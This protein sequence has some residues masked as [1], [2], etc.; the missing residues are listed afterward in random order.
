MN[1]VVGSSISHTLKLFT[2]ATPKMSQFRSLDAA[3]GRCH[4]SLRFCPKCASTANLSWEQ[5]AVYPW[6]TVLCCSSCDIRWY[7]CRE[8][9]GVRSHYTKVPQL[10]RHARNCH[11]ISGAA[12]SNT[13]N[14]TPSTSRAESPAF[15]DTTGD[16]LFE[17][18]VSDPTHSAYPVCEVES[19]SSNQFHCVAS[20]SIIDV[21]EMKGLNSLSEKYFKHQFIDKQGGLAHVVAMSQFQVE[22]YR[23]SQNIATPEIQYHLDF[24]MLVSKLSRA[25]RS[26]LADVIKQTVSITT[27]RITSPASSSSDG[28]YKA[29]AIATTAEQIRSTYV[30]GKYAMLQNLPR[31]QVTSFDGHGYVSLRECISDILAHGLDLDDIVSQSENPLVAKLSECKVSQSIFDNASLR[32]VGTEQPIVLYFNEWSDDFD[33]SS[34]STR[35]NRGSVWMKSVTISPPS[36]Q[37]HSLQYTYPIAIGKKASSHESV[38][39]RFASEVIELSSGD[40]N[41]FYCESLKK[42]VRVHVEM[43]ASLQDQPER[44]Q[45]NCIMLGSGRYCARWGYTANFTKIASALISCQDCYHSLL[46]GTVMP[47]HCPNCVNWNLMADSPLLKFPPPDD[48]PIDALEDNATTLRPRRITYVSLADAV[49]R[50]HTAVITGSWTVENARSYLLTEGLNTETASEVMECATNVRALQFL[51]DNKENYHLEYEAMVRDKQRNPSS[52]DVWKTPAI[53]RRGTSLFQH[54]DAVMHLIFLGVFK[55]S[56]KRIEEWLKGRNK[57]DSFHR[58]AKQTLN[59]VSSLSVSWCRVLPYKSGKFTG[60]ISE[61]FLAFSRL[62]LW[63]YAP[64]ASIASD[65]IPPPA[66]N[67][68]QDKWSVQE[69]RK[70]LSQRGLD[71]TGNAFTLRTR[72]LHYM[73]LP[74]GPPPILGPTGGAVS[75]VLFMLQALAFMV[76]NVMTPVTST[77]IILKVERS[78][79]IFL[80][81]FDKFDAGLRKPEQKPTW[82]TSY[83]FTCL[84]NLPDVMNNYGPLLNLWEGGGQGEKILQQVKPLWLGFRKNWQQSILT[85][86]LNERALKLMM[87]S[88]IQNEDKASKPDDTLR[89]ESMYHTYADVADVKRQMRRRVAMSAVF[90][91][92]GELVFLIRSRSGMAFHHC[93]IEEAVANRLGLLYFNVTAAEANLPRLVMGDDI[94]VIKEYCVLLPELRVTGL[95]SL[96]EACGWAILNNKWE[97][98]HEDKVF[99]CPQLVNELL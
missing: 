72:V 4:Y 61:N 67:R 98:Y 74:E 15:E 30:H 79:K 57:S 6:A 25:D 65:P 71:V 84:L 26:L 87:K 51:S 86:M 93:V 13:S 91:S 80:T 42:S 85:R 55:T 14:T 73:S 56:V 41:W 29:T 89:V 97:M 23:P 27:D 31:P 45:A 59:S 70:W 94:P 2:S 99:K 32:N 82:V 63:F 66:P 37:L 40:N 53:W 1:R 60:W 12:T 24:C 3:V 62:I 81:A 38:E 76:A 90:L 96:G 28:V 16:N 18:E 36:H 64:L 95:P 43:M 58:F 20:A 9:F 7:L 46:Y 88:E 39:E 33:P 5:H 77:A 35:N 19:T 8:C 44:R 83:N 68:P 78:I 22:L 10:S 17:V 69:N 47:N 75:E 52:Y 54:V 49:Q 11:G 92:T 21:P 50:A 34:S 48:Y